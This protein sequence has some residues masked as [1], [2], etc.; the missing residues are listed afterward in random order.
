MF[1]PLNG[2]KITDSCLFTQSPPLSMLTIS[3][4]TGDPEPPLINNDHPFDSYTIDNNN[5]LFEFLSK[6]CY[7]PQ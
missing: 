1:P 7:G 6:V 3:A 2:T 4:M 5:W